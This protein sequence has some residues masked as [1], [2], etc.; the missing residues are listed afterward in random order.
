MLL[1]FL[2]FHSTLLLRR[3]RGAFPLPFG[4]Y[5]RKRRR[6]EGEECPFPRILRFASTLFL[7]FLLQDSMDLHYSFFTEN[8][9]APKEVGRTPQEKVGDPG[10]GT[11]VCPSYLRELSASFHVYFTTCLPLPDCLN[12]SFHIRCMPSVFFPSLFFS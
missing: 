6:A 5:R 1:P 3:F 11:S 8:S 12:R 10:R 2:S 7:Y 4:P 9:I